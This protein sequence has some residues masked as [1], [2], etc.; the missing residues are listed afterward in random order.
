MRH[1]PQ[2][3]SIFLYRQETI[4]HLPF[5][6]QVRKLFS[7]F[8]ISFTVHA[9][10]RHLAVGRITRGKTQHI[11]KTDATLQPTGPAC[12]HEYAEIINRE[13]HRIGHPSENLKSCHIIFHVG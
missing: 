1:T 5:E 2:T 11:L 3:S 7:P 13:E 8:S 9:R 12:V 6:P 4:E 10:A